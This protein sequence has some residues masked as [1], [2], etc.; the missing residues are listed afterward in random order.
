MLR[1]RGRGEGKKKEGFFGLAGLGNW[2]ACPPIVA[3]ALS[4]HCHCAPRDLTFS[5]SPPLALL[6]AVLVR[7]AS[8]LLSPAELRFIGAPRKGP[9]GGL[10]EF[11][12]YYNAR[13]GVLRLFLRAFSRK[14]GGSARAFTVN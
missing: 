5:V 1:W 10:G 12:C 6:G 8:L 4:T 9:L 7:C 11:I 13:W 14:E 3:S 2:S